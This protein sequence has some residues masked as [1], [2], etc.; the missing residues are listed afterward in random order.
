MLV[1]HCVEAS[2]INK[3]SFVVDPTKIRHVIVKAGKI[4][5]MSGYVDPLTH[6]NLDFP[7][8]RVDLCVISEAWEK[9]AKIRYC[10]Q[11]FEVAI[12]PRVAFRHLGPVDSTQRLLD[13]KESVRALRKV[14][15]SEAKIN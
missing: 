12:V 8:H 13:M 14:K 10:D 2:N 9:G 3:K 4:E 7:D 11:G 5:D 6:L 1:H 15:K